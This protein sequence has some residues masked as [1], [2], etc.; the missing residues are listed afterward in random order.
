MIKNPITLISTS[1]WKK[2]AFAGPYAPLLA[3]YIIG[4][5]LLV[6]SRLA[7]VL[8]Q[9]E[10]VIATGQMLQVFMQGFRVDLILLGLIVLIP[11]L[12]SSLFMLLKAWKPWQWFTRVWLILS[13]VLI[14]F[15]EIASFGF[16]AEYDVRPNRLFIEY[17]KYPQEVIPMLWNGFRIHVFLALTALI[18]TVY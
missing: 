6:L 9:S 7:L 11:I 10:R 16:I 2:L 13:I 18:V 4:L 15:L 12:L 8:W 3:L 17:L 1:I 5:P 14:V